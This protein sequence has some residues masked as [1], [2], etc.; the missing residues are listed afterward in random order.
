MNEVL[1]FWFGRS[2]S[3]EFGKVHKKWFEKDADFDA[4]VR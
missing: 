3:P 2:H 1:D 4:Q